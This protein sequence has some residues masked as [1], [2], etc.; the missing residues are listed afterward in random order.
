M[1]VYV[2]VRVCLVQLASVFVE[3]G[4][5]F[6]LRYVSTGCPCVQVSKCPSDH[7]NNC[8]ATQITLLDAFGS[9]YQY[10]N[11]PPRDYEKHCIQH[12]LLSLA[13]RRSKAR[14]LQ[15]STSMFDDVSGRTQYAR[16]LSYPA[17]QLAEHADHA[18]NCQRGHA[19][20]EHVRLWAGLDRGQRPLGQ[21][22]SRV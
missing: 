22:T 5:P 15:Y 14:L 19:S 16:L 11:Y 7:L 2:Y 18:P 3:Y 13:G 17:P 4:L 1:Y 21:V 20:T 10:Y 8:P 12:D 6:N 9:L